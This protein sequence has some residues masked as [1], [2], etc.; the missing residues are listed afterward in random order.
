MTL[1]GRGEMV[2]SGSMIWRGLHPSLGFVSRGPARA[3]VC[4]LVALG[5]GAAAGQA[6]AQSDTETRQ[7]LDAAAQTLKAKRDAEKGLAGDVASLQV[8]REKLNASLLDTAKKIQNSEGRLTA[9]EDRIGELEAQEKLLRGSLAERHGS[10]ARLLSAMQRMGRDPPPV[11]ITRRED[12]LVMVRSA[13][14]LARSF[15]H[16]KDQAL[17]LAARLE[18][19]ARVMGESRAEGDK[20]KGET[21]RLTEARVRL[22]QLME[23]K[24]QSLSS[25]Q[26]ALERVRREAEE[27][28]KSVTD[29]SELIEK[30]DVVVAKQ[31]GP[32]MA[33]A[34]PAPGRPEAAP[35]APASAEPVTPLRRVEDGGPAAV[36]AVPQLPSA[37]ELAPKGP[38]IANL[39]AGR[40]KPAIPFA[41][42]RGR[43][44][45]P[46][47]GRRIIAFGDKAQSNRSSGVVFETRAGAQVISPTD[48]WVVF[49]GAFRSYGQILIINAGDGYHMLLAG[50][51]QADVQLGQ[52]VLAGEPVGLMSGLPK[53]RKAK[54]PASTAVLYVELRKDSKPIDPDPWWAN[55]NTKKVQG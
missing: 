42:A 21:Q 24:R 10:I 1:A 37:V 4:A 47:Q 20:L 40:I 12:A 34:M 55:D 11:M 5:L 31:A 14:M 23:E 45:Y 7:R 13:M 36:P 41:E 43:L 19:L 32:A 46:V 9:I 38:R 22:S 30:L 15:P 2:R 26:A 27:I 49:A 48:G 50:L 29:L 51:S 53:D 44:P 17:A 18:E 16:L 39:N 28:A 3:L 25:R 52:F 35:E 54:A 33:S 8:E 6:R